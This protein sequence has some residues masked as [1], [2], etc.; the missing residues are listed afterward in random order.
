[1]HHVDALAVISK[2]ITRAIVELGGRSNPVKFCYGF[3]LTELAA[4]DQVLI[5]L[6][7]RHKHCGCGF[8][9]VLAVLKQ[10]FPQCKKFQ[11]RDY[12]QCNQ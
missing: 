3:F 1:M 8:N 4:I 11:R 6:C 10:G 2:E 7:G 5:G 9:L 12:K